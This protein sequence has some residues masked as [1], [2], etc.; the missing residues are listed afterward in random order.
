VL[1]VRLAR[2]GRFLGGRLWAVRLGPP[3]V[4]KRDP[5]GAGIRL[6]RRLS[7]ADFGGRACRVSSSGLVRPR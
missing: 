4:P 1:Q 6:V 5:S 3:G 2:S 7:I